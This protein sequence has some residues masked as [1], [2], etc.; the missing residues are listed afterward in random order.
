MESTPDY[1]TQEIGTITMVYA[2]SYVPQTLQ[3]A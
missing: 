2:Y 3:D 1:H